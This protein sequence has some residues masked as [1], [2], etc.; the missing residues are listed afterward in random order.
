MWCCYLLFN[1]VSSVREE[2][3]SIWLHAPSSIPLL[4]ASPASLG[5]SCKVS[6]IKEARSGVFWGPRWRKWL[7]SCMR[8]PVPLGGFV[9]KEQSSAL[10]SRF[11]LLKGGCPVLGRELLAYQRLLLLR[12]VPRGSGSWAGGCWGTACENKLTGARRMA[13]LFCGN[14]FGGFPKWDAGDVSLPSFTH[15]G[16]PLCQRAF[17]ILYTA[18]SFYW[19]P[20]PGW[21]MT[22]SLSNSTD[23]SR[24]W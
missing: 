4:S 21:L 18:K 19:P 17:G 22:T 10:K 2:S 15:P 13:P 5:R 24:S 7:F 14:S 20:S 12:M 1:N 9:Y 8:P 3:E 23:A 6:V 11:G 16:C